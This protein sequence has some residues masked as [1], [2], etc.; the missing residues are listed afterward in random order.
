MTRN[1]DKR[2]EL[3]FPVEQPEH[4]TRVLAVLR[5]MFR[6]NVKARWL[7]PDGT[8]KRRKR[9]AG[10]P[11]FRVQ[12]FLREETRRAAALERERAGVRFVPEERKDARSDW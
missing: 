2:V 8:Y 7:T 12:Q 3:L 4:R 5:A 11:P 10:E 1:L 6:D 9:A